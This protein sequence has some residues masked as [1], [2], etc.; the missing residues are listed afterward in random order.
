MLKVS[1]LMTTD[2]PVFNTDQLISASKAAK[3][4]GAVR[5]SA[6]KAPQYITDNGEVDSVILGYEYF[7]QM[8][9][10]LQE[11]EELEETRILSER[12]DRLDNEPSSA[13]SWKDIRRS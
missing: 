8:F 7:E 5:E 4:F 3:K 6:K 9:S 1:E 10:R 12:I 2:K 11:L 13:V